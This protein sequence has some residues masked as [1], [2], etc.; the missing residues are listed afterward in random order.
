MPLVQFREPD[1]QFIDPS[2][3]WEQQNQLSGSEKDIDPPLKKDPPVYPEVEQS[4]NIND[5]EK[6]IVIDWDSFKIINI[7]SFKYRNKKN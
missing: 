1:P 3:N 6:Q 2:L 5:E 7:P 4:Y